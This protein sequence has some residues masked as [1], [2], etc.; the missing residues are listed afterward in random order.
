[1]LWHLCT[2]MDGNGTTVKECELIDS[3]EKAIVN[4]TKNP[5]NNG[6]NVNEKKPFSHIS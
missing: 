1:M 6:A 3:F 5:A 4:L 2:T